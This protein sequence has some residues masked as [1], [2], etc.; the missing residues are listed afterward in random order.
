MSFVWKQL[1]DIPTDT[2]TKVQ[3]GWQLRLWNDAAYLFTGN[4]ISIWAYNLANGKW[5]RKRTTFKAR[6]GQKWPYKNC[7]VDQYSSLVMEDKLYVFGGDDNNVCL[8]TNILT[9][10]NLKT[11]T[12]EHISGTSDNVPQVFEP[13]LRRQAHMW[14]VPEQ[15]RFYLLYGNAGRMNAL[16]NHKVWGFEHDYTYDDFWSFDIVKRKWHRE[17]MRGNMPSPRTEASAI[18][19][20]TLKQA[21]VYG[22]YNSSTA[23]S[24]SKESLY[25]YS[26][27]GDTFLFDPETKLWKH[28]LTRGFP[29][30]RATAEFAIDPSTGK[31]YLYGGK[32]FSNHSQTLLDSSLKF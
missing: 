4:P 8:G 6:A 7:F 5:E 29:S 31:T 25:T 12:W 9:A 21:I 26:Y 1:D 30:Y 19:H 22:G 13:N 20:P 32:A 3:G 28:V 10:L 23:T 14:A 11:L 2:S 16:L 24:V 27:Y 15:R 18:Y 17:R